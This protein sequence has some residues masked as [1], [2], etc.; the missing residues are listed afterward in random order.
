MSSGTHILVRFYYTITP[1]KKYTFDLLH[2]L[3]STKRRPQFSE[4]GF[5]DGGNL[6][7]YSQ[8]SINTSSVRPS[9]DITAQ[10]N[11]AD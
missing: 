5:E 3:N 8:N 2:I 11:D 10:E 6:L 7:V 4:L 9:G 1:L